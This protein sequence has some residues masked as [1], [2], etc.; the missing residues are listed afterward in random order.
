[1]NMVPKA[2]R[3]TQVYEITVEHLLQRR[4]GDR[5]FCV[6][7]N[8]WPITVAARSEASVCGRSLGGIVGSNP[9]GSVDV[10]LLYSVCVLSGRGLYVWLITR[11]EEPYLP[12]V[13]CLQCDGEVP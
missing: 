11:P 1:M 8:V 9:A 2:N 5:V 6:V 4:K 3:C 10:R 13:V 12:S 7:T